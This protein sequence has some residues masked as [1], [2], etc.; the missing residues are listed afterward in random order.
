[1]P[2][3][4]N[5]I[6]E[7]KIFPPLLKF[8]VPMMLTLLLQ[9]LYGA[10]DLAAVGRFGSPSSVSAVSNGSQ[11]M[12]TV[13]EFI[14]GL[15]MGLTVLIGRFS[16]AKDD[17]SAAR[18]LGGA[19]KLFSA[20]GVILTA[21]MI[22]FA[23]KITGLMQVP[24]E[25]RENT[26][27]YL[28]I[29]SSGLIFIT[30]FNVI[31]ALFRGL[32]NSVSP[33]IFIAVASVV[34]IGFNLL[35]VGVFKLGAA[36]A[37]IATVIAQAASVSFSLYKIKK[38]A[39]PFKFA[40]R[41]FKASGTWLKSLM[42]IG[43]PVALQGILTSLSFLI[44]MAII[45]SISLVASVSVGI[46]EKL[47]LFLALVP[48]SFMFALSAFTAQNVG[49]KQEARALKALRA[50]IVVAAA[51]GFVMFLAT[52]FEG[53]LLAGAF[54]QERE[55]IESTR[56]YLRGI[57]AEYLFLPFIFCLLGYF[58]GIGKTAF[59]LVEGLIAAFV[60][61]IPLCYYFSRLPD[62]NLTTIGLTVP[63]SSLASLIMCVGYFFVVRRKRMGLHGG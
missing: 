49:A 15:A 3:G 9:A 52:F 40:R 29:C 36:G 21:V 33:L 42:A 59:V 54:S 1:M 16:G 37:A 50:A 35:L 41:H 27:I 17:E 45:N 4:E 34:N 12:Q 58:N 2:N 23:G 31:S 28:R 46:A 39:L 5:T 19:I 6:L 53:R 18:T 43:A 32:G 61:R 14:A 25:A 60:F 8:A 38:D 62:T 30:A 48:M 44:I 47:F 11:I 56:S 10:V 7:G 51:F 55:I 24:D 26:V 63:L 22:V 13:S 20:V 57:A